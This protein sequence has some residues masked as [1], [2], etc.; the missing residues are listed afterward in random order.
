MHMAKQFYTAFINEG[1]HNWKIAIERFR[2][3]EASECHREAVLK[4]QTLKAPTVVEQLSSQAAKT[5]AL[6]RR[7][8]LKQL[9]SLR[10]LLRQGLTIRG[11]RDWEGNL[12]QLLHLQ[13]NDSHELAGW[14]TNKQYLST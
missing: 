12:M 10:F 9:T 8:L 7:M 11:H 3:H 1:F 4:I 13:S 14:L 2:R 5:R 6:N